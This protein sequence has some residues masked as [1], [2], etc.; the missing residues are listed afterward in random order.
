MAINQGWV[1][2]PDRRPSTNS[3]DK[4]QS[5]ILFL[6]IFICIRLLIVLTF[7]IAAYPVWF[8][9]RRKRIYVQCSPEHTRN[10]ASSR[11]NLVLRFPTRYDSNWPTQLHSLARVWNVSGSSVYIISDSQTALM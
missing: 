8:T 11:E 5:K 4:W 9:T 10:C 2:T 1:Y 6:T 3:G 7:L